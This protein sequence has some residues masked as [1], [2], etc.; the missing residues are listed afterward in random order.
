M[1][2]YQR[3]GQHAVDGVSFDLEPGGGFLVAGDAGSGKTS[4]LRAVLGLVAAQGEITVL[5]HAP[6]DPALAGRIGYGPQGRTFAEAH[7]PV[8]LVRLVALVRG[9]R[10]TGVS[11]TALERAGI[12]PGRRNARVLDIEELRR[13]ALACAIVGEPDLIVLDDPWEFPETVE[14]IARARDRGAAVLAATHDPGGLPAL[15]GTTL[16]LVDGAVA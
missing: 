9:I 10:G 14:E 4:L 1:V 13:L 2:V 5:G 7:P 11:D 16:T 6:G 12:P 3:G 8:A 15:L